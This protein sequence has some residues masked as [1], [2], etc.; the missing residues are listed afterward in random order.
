MSNLATEILLAI[1]TALLAAVILVPTFV[2][3][4]LLLDQGLAVLLVVVVVFGILL[5]YALRRETTR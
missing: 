2:V 1:A 4:K 5:A 3:L